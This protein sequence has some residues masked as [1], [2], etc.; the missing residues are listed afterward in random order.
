VQHFR[1][2]AVAFNDCDVPGCEQLEPRTMLG[3]SNGCY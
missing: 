2:L 1:S 3:W